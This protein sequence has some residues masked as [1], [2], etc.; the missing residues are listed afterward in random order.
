MK[1]WLKFFKFSLTFVNGGLSVALVFYMAKDLEKFKPNQEERLEMGRIILVVLF[2]FNINLIAALLI[3]VSALFACC[4]FCFGKLCCC[5]DNNE[6]YFK[7]GENSARAFYNLI[8]GTYDRVFC[9]KKF[10][11][12]NIIIQVV[13]LILTFGFGAICIQLYQWEHMSHVV[14]FAFLLSIPFGLNLII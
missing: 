3:L 12:F 8:T 7:F 1:G 2:V 5:N 10:C 11:A 4:S 13:F 6:F 14:M 9:S